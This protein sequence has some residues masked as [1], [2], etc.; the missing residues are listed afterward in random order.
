MP[1]QPLQGRIL[2]GELIASLA[3]RTALETPGVLRLEPTVQGLLARLGPTLLHRPRNPGSE[4]GADRHDGVTATVTDGVARVHLDLATDIAC[5][6]LDVA[7][8]VRQRIRES[9]ARTGLAPGEV[10]I[11]ILAIE[12]SR[13]PE[14]V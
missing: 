4:E 9:I 8:A 6:A 3:A 7:Q 12:P 13:R 2:T 11:S 10:D 1:E 14:P 5:T